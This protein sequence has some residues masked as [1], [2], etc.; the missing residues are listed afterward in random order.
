LH[1]NFLLSCDSVTIF[2]QI[3][4]FANL[5]SPYSSEWMSQWM[6]EWVN[7]RMNE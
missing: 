5:Q 2:S 6:N 7:Q 3:L 4:I 1:S